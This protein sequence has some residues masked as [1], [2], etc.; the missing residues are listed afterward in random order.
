MEKSTGYGTTRTVRMRITLGTATLPSRCSA[1]TLS[2]SL[3]PLWPGEV[4]ECVSVGLTEDNADIRAM[5]FCYVSLVQACT[6]LLPCMGRCNQVNL[7]TVGLRT[8]MICVETVIWLIQPLRIRL[9][10]GSFSILTCLLY[11]VEGLRQRCW[12]KSLSKGY[13]DS[14]IIN[15]LFV[16]YLTVSNPDDKTQLNENVWGLSLVWWK[17]LCV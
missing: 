7:L 12:L 8:E 13:V 11:C 3:L 17:G 14:C 10:R 16:F 4:P 2:H 6:L 5:I 15:N 1:I 9:A